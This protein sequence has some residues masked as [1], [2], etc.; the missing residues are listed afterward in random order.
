MMQEKVINVSDKFK[1]QKI[2]S[3]YKRAELA[4]KDSIENMKK[5]APEYFKNKSV[6]FC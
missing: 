1:Q 6:P 5:T 4:C 2:D 3:L